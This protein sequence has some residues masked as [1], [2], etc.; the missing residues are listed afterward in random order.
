MKRVPGVCA[1]L[2]ATQ[3]KLTEVP[4]T[5]S[6]TSG[7]EANASFGGASLLLRSLGGLSP[8]NLPSADWATPQGNFSD[9]RGHPN[10]RG[11]VETQ[12][13]QGP[14]SPDSAGVG[15]GLRLRFFAGVQAGA[16]AAG[17]EPTLRTTGLQLSA[18]VPLKCGE[19][20]KTLRPPSA[21]PQAP[22]RP[23]ALTVVRPTSTLTAIFRAK[24][25]YGI[26]SKPSTYSSQKTTLLSGTHFVMRSRI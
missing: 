11:L 23:W 16:G 4:S 7:F 19:A 21:A 18:P 13:A 17:G 1:G 9:P 2:G 12:V 8:H 24:G 26:F 6:Q 10:P 25:P 22:T 20:A 3:T 14:G 5:L 15:G